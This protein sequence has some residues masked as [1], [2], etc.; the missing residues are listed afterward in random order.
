MQVPPIISLIC[1]LFV[2]NVYSSTVVAQSEAPYEAYE[3]SL[4]HYQEKHA[5]E[6]YE[7]YLKRLHKHFIKEDSIEKFNLLDKYY[8]IPVDTL[9]SALFRELFLIKG[10]YTWRYLGDYEKSLNFYLTAHDQLENKKEGDKRS[11]FVENT[12]GTIYTRL[13]DYEKAHYF[14]KL[15]EQHFKHQNSEKNLARLY[16]NMARNHRCRKDYTSAIEILKKGIQ[17]SDNDQLSMMA[18]WINLAD[19]YIE[20][21]NI[22]DGKKSIAETKQ[23]DPTL[24]DDRLYYLY[25]LEGDIATLEKDGLKAK[26]YYYASYQEL[27]KIHPHLYRREVSKLLNKMA[28]SYRAHDSLKQAEQFAFLGLHYLNRDIDSTGIN[29]IE[30]HHL[31]P[32]NTFI[33]L[34]TTLSKIESDK[35]SISEDTVSLNRAIKYTHFARNVN[36]RLRNT[37]LQEPSKLLSVEL[38]KSLLNQAIDLNFLAYQKHGDTS[39]ILEAQ[40]LFSDSKA[41]LYN[42]KIQLAAK[43]IPNKHLKDTEEELIQLIEKKHDIKD[44]EKMDSINQLIFKVETKLQHDYTQLNSVNDKEKKR[45]NQN[46]I[47]YVITNQEVYSICQIDQTIHYTHHGKSDAL[48]SLINEY[49][50][51]VSQHS[52]LTSFIKVSHQLYLFL[53]KDLPEIK[54]KITI[55]PDESLQLVSFDGLCKDIAE[56]TYLGKEIT[57]S[58]LFS[59]LSV[60]SNPREAQKVSVFTHIP[61]YPDHG[62]LNNTPFKPLKHLAKEADLVAKYFD[63]IPV[64]KVNLTSSEYLDSISKASIFHFAGHAQVQDQLAYL[65]LAI[66]DTLRPI[67]ADQIQYSNCQNKLVALSACETALGEIKLGEGIQSLGRSFMIAGAES[68]LQSL[69]KVD[70][71]STAIIMG[72]FYKYLAQ[73]KEKHVALREAKKE[74][75]STSPP[76]N[77]HPY[78]W[79]GFILT[80]NTQAMVK[81]KQWKFVYPIVV[82][83]VIFLCFKL[84]ISNRQK[85]QTI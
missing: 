1:L 73:G 2:L 63:H 23:I 66:N 46:Y 53:F 16:T 9:S 25:E 26:D 8:F 27:K 47:E 18:N 80:G 34:L 12:I 35:Y 39:F 29:N 22:E 68:V 42:E 59:A 52:N 50:S 84:L 79:S 85:N 15:T 76:E 51:L 31:Y 60:D 17:I 57:I 54:N 82:L 70:D 75:I 64:S 61:S 83:G 81:T 6:Q 71:Q 10:Y 3:D 56:K 45:I 58:Y 5:W 69:W 21:G 20:V 43:E 41:I 7:D 32:E 72:D 62:T 74:F 36:R 28:N 4:A 30:K 40:Q 33:E 24:L 13:G 77:R 49:R 48:I 78:Y 37:Y 55:I 11:W 44:Q 65:V 14:L 67:Y 19:I 38:N